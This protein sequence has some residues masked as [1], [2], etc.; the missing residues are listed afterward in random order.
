[1]DWLRGSQNSGS[2]AATRRPANADA[3]RPA[4][5]DRAGEPADAADLARTQRLAAIAARQAAR[6]EIRKRIEYENKIV[7]HT[8]LDSSLLLLLKETRDWPARNQRGALRQNLLFD[9]QDIR[10]QEQQS[11]GLVTQR[12]EFTFRGARYRVEVDTDSERTHLGKT[13]RLRIFQNDKVML[14]AHLAGPADG[15]TAP[16]PWDRL[17]VD[18]LE[19]G[20]WVG[21]IGE[22][23][24]QIRFARERP[25][26]QQEF[27]RLMG[28][29]DGSPTTG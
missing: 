22:I 25:V 17:K 24:E 1:M 16:A 5:T 3:P 4:R 12:V 18:T 23:E 13:G 9:A 29:D 14:S 27:A 15:D 21:H 10:V 8:H 26:L 7:H 2:S 28:D 20:P 11:A 19:P 6:A